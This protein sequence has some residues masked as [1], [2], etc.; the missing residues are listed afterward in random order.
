MLKKSAHML[1]YGILMAWLI[2]ARLAWPKALL[3][4]IIYAGSDELHQRFV[5]GRTSRLM[6]IGFDTGG[7]LL[8]LQLIKLRWQKVWVT[9]SPRETQ[10]LAGVILEAAAAEGINMVSVQGELGAGKT[11]LIQGLGKELGI[12]QNLPSP[13]FIIMRSYKLAMGPWRQLD[14]LD[15]YRMDSDK[16]IRSVNLREIW[17]DKANLVVIEWAE[18]IKQG[19]PKKYL[20]VEMKIRG[21]QDREVRLRLC[22]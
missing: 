20:A 5:P 18:R 6:D 19:L 10:K 7:M 2:R 4:G 14:H 12:R 11:T 8:A 15:L 21:E 22:G 1:E 17:T 16:E 3:I 13:T 9:R